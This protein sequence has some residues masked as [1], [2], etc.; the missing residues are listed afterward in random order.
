MEC[1]V[2]V[3]EEAFD[4]TQSPHPDL[5][6]AIFDPFAKLVQIEVVGQTFSVPENNTL[7]RCFQYVEIGRASCR[8]RVYSSV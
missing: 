2:A 4:L 5:D 3:A 7:M 1:A 8:E 6:L